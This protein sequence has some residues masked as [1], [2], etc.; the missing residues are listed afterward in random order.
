MTQQLLPGYS[1]HSGTNQD[2]S[3]L[4][5]FMQQSYQEIFPKQNF[6]HLRRTVERYFSRDTP[7][8]WVEV[9][10]AREKKAEEAEGAEEESQFHD[11]KSAH[12]KSTIPSL[13]TPHSSLLKVACLWVGNAVDQ[14][15]GD[16][17]TYIFLLYVKPEYRRRGIGKAL[18]RYLE[19]W[20]RTKGDRQIG[21][22][23][24]QSNTPALDLYHKLGYQI[25][26][27]WMIKRL[28][29]QE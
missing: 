8:W 1:I 26:S 14:V 19:D 15:K 3:L 27:H 13:L 2:R 11:L 20:A 12:S 10:G 4:I 7:L 5:Q 21:L 24:F 6:A 18:M 22:Q 16:R 25:Q 28:E 29:E 17:H 23:V 9:E